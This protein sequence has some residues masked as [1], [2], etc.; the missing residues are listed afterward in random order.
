[1]LLCQGIEQLQQ[2]M[3]WRRNSDRLCDYLKCTQRMKTCSTR[4]FDGLT[5]DYMAPASSASSQGSCADAFL[6]DASWHRFGAGP[7]TDGGKETA[8]P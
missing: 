8:I 1:M 5:I 3:H 6:L 2:E 4:S 7:L